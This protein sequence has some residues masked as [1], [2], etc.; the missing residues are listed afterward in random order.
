MGGLLKDTS[1]NDK[2]SWLDIPQMILSMKTK[3]GE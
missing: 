1:V 3:E 2:I